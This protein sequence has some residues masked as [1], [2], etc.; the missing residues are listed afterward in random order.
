MSNVAGKAYGINV[1]TPM[2]PNLTWVQ[3]AIF[4]ASRA[5]PFS[6]RGLLGRSILAYPVRCQSRS[7]VSPVAAVEFFIRGG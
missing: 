6:L 7:R 2:H 3:R 4:M 1:I 5:L